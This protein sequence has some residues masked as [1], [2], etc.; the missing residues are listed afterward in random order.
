VQDV[1]LH[2]F[3]DTIVSCCQALFSGLEDREVPPSKAYELCVSIPF[4][5]AG[6]HGNIVLLTTRAFARRSLPAGVLERAISE[7]PYLAD[8]VCEAANQLLGRMKNRLLRVGM[9]LEIGLASVIGGDQIALYP[10]SEGRHSE[11]AFTLHGEPLALIWETIVVNPAEVRR[12]DRIE[13]PPL[14]EGELSLF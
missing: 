2:D 13:E 14:S 11:R 8:W 4:Q 10:L 3:D 1:R 5:S 9:V 6:F 12:S 7:Y